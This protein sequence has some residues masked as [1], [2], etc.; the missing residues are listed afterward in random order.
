MNPVGEYAA[1]RRFIRNLHQSQFE[2]GA[3]RLSYGD[4][5]LEIQLEIVDCDTFEMVKKIIHS[6]LLTLVYRCH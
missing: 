2:Q 5:G 4:K 6:L 1:L 3:D